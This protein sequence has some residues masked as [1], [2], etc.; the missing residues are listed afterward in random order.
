M[1]AFGAH[2]RTCRLSESG[3]RSGFL[4]GSFA[5]AFSFLLSRM[6]YV[7]LLYPSFDPISSQNLR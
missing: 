5:F 4:I 6:L 1:C 2:S 3:A 7:S